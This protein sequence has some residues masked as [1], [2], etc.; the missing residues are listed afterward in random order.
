VSYAN[1]NKA[2]NN[3][4][5]VLASTTRALTGKRKLQVGFEDAPPAEE[6]IT[7]PSISEVPDNSI[8]PA[9]RGAADHAALSLRYHN[10]VLHRHH[11]PA[12][13][14]ASAVFDALENIRVESVGSNDMSGVKYNLYRR[15]E[16]EAMQR[17]LN[18]GVL[19]LADGVELFARRYIQQMPV[20]DFLSEIMENSE[21]RF[22]SAL[23]LLEKLRGR[24]HD[25]DAYASLSLELIEV[26]S[27]AANAAEPGDDKGGTQQKSDKQ[28]D[29]QMTDQ[30]EGTMI[31]A[32]DTSDDEAT[33]TVQGKVAPGGMGSEEAEPKKGE[34]TSMDQESPY[35]YGHNIEKMQEGY[36]AY[37]T[38]FD[39]VVSASALASQTEL[40]HLRQQLDQKLSQFQSVT[41]R[42]ASK[43]Q[44]LLM[45]KQARHWVFDEED[46]IIDNRK[47]SR[48]II[49]PDFDKIY[50]YEKD[51]EFRDTVVTLLID[52]SG[53]MRGRPITIA[54]LSADIISRTLERCG[55]KVEILGFTTKEWKGGNS[56][57]LWIKNNRP[58]HAGRLN[59]LRHIIYKSAD[60]SWRKAR[61]N[62]GLMLKDG[63]LKENI[64]GEALIWAYERLLARPEQRR[65]LMV[66]SD[67]APVDDS[68]LSV[69]G[70]SYLDTHLRDVIKRIEAGKAVELLAIGIGHDVTRYYQHAVTISEIDKLGETMTQQLTSLFTEKGPAKRRKKA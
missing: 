43:L 4:K 18:A 56:Y 2:L 22:K 19:P 49:H 24:T 27:Q 45:A 10:P 11:R 6:G 13:I 33:Q 1:D 57:K 14:T 66:I 46:G 44:R 9:I 31:S 29:S 54:A 32:G 47:L 26:L 8:L 52:N 15:F 37:S 59:D 63:V 62:L 39:E 21:S 34:S 7:L 60:S 67:G 35:P 69:N 23:P 36:H 25:Q 50:K 61:R 12:D 20:P 28:P 48:I 51:T 70:G 16:R 64:D 17:G 53:S 65:I 3:F 41:A 68:T 42:L 58:S 30:A 40:D 5:Q 38:Q 55:V